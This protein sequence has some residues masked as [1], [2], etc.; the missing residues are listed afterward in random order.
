MYC[1][2]NLIS[3]LPAHLK[4]W[5]PAGGTG[6]ADAQLVLAF[7]LVSQMTGMPL[8]PLLEKLMGPRLTAALGGIMM[9]VG[10]FLSS[11]AQNLKQ[12]VLCYSVLFGLGVGI[13]YQMP[14]LVGGRF[15]PQRKGTVQVSMGTVPGCCLLPAACCLLSAACFL[16]SRLHKSAR[17]PT[18]AAFTPLRDSTHLCAAP[19]GSLPAPLLP[20]QGAVVTGMGASAFIFN[21]LA[22]RL[23]NPT[24]LDSIGGAFPAVVT[25][26]WP[27][28]LRTLAVSFGALSLAG[29]CL[30]ANPTSH[31]GSYPLL[32]A[33]HS[34][35]SKGK[36]TP[37]GSNKWRGGGGG[38]GTQ[39]KRSGVS[40]AWVAA[41]GG[42]GSGPAAA[43]VSPTRSALHDIF[44][45][46]FM[47][48]WLMILLS[49]VSG[50]W[51]PNTDGSSRL[52]AAATLRRRRVSLLLPQPPSPSPPPS[53]LN[54]AST[55]KTYATKLPELNSDAF[56]SFVGAISAI[57]TRPPR[58][59]SLSWSRTSL[60]TVSCLCC[61]S[62]TQVATPLA[63]SSG[64][65]S[66]T[67]SAS[68]LASAHSPYCR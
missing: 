64:V 6:P 1:W 12:F 61:S 36:T 63:A 66:P 44:S 35:G 68:K 5:D 18:F 2:G 3:Y 32:N 41:A 53:G 43:G 62:L 59:T 10:V 31:A 37:G 25:A 14:F 42:G 19:L 13:A 16:L 30:Q 9:G 52:L 34:L 57:G 50:Q 15:F 24:G 11:Y 56:L 38:G 26:C 49:A 67:P 4:Y 22:T 27:M 21:L 65:P 17:P 29:A 51:G 20:A 28:M 48:L 33:F 54:I 47:V 8:G 58:F 55:Y 7:I 23:V 40:S 39:P 45:G 60:T 46:R